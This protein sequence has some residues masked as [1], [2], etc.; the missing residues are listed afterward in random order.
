MKCPL[1]L[2]TQKRPLGE[3]AFGVPEQIEDFD[4][5]IEESCAWWDLKNK[6]CII[7]HLI[8]IEEKLEILKQKI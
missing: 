1:R 3:A 8:Y 2:R 4:F 7:T 6:C 5:C